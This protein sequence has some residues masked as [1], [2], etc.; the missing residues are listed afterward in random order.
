VNYSIYRSRKYPHVSVE[1]KLT[2]YTY[3]VFSIANLS[4]SNT[5]K[6][7][8]TVKFLTERYRLI[9]NLAENAA[10]HWCYQ[11]EDIELENRLLEI[12]PNTF[13]HKDYSAEILQNVQ[14][15][16]LLVVDDS[17]QLMGSADMLQLLIRHFHHM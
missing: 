16:S 1:I 3:C 4:P 5:G 13:F 14:R 17:Y 11:S 6:T 7:E 8:W 10:I 12:C 15:G 2:K 9:P